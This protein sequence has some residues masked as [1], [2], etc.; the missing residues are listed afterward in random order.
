METILPILMVRQLLWL[1]IILKFDKDIQNIHDIL[2]YIES[3]K[4]VGNNILMIV[5]RNGNIQFSTVRLGSNS[6]YLPYLNKWQ[7]TIRRS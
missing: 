3:K 4:N 1:G 5:L 2:A 7:K 6:N